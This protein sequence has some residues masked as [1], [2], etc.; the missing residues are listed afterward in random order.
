M[1]TKNILLD[2]LFLLNIKYVNNKDY[3]ICNMQKIYEFFFIK[4]TKYSKVLAIF[5][6]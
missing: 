4:L 1:T 3:K 6:F 5:I 2:F